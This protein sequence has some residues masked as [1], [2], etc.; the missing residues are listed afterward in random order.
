MTMMTATAAAVAAA[1]TNRIVL[2]NDVCERVQETHGHF[3]MFLSWLL[4]L[5]LLAFFS[6][7]HLP[8]ERKKEKESHNVYELRTMSHLA[9]IIPIALNLKSI[10]IINTRKN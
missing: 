6:T 4:L 10:L 3:A 5:L 7:L 2:T 1:A 8:T 9:F